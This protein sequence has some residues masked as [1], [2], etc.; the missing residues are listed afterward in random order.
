M[1]YLVD[2]LGANYAIHGFGFGFGFGFGLLVLF[3]LL[4][5]LVLLV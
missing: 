1:L 4:G 3:G 2:F 5:L